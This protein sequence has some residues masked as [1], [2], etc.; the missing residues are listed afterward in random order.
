MYILGIGEDIPGTILG[1]YSSKSIEKRRK[2]T[3]VRSTSSL[4][5]L[6]VCED[7]QMTVSGYMRKEAKRQRLDQHLPCIF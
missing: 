4:Y 1:Y 6:E 7:I 2:E 3:N 5:L